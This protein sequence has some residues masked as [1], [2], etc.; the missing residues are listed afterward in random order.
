MDC[1][2]KQEVGIERLDNGF[3]V[4]IVRGVELVETPL[5]TRHNVET[6]RLV[7]KSFREAIMLIADYFGLGDEMKE[8]S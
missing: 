7:A 5:G 3:L 6:K 4:T 2:L 1:D 8:R